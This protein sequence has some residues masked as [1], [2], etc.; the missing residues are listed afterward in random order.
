MTFKKHWLVGAALITAGTLA[1]TACTGGGAPAPA[2]AGTAKVDTAGELSGTI[3]FQ[4]W[5]LKNE[6]FTPYFTTLISDFT[7]E[8]PKVTI[9]W[10]DQPG[11]GY[12][13]KVL[14]QANSNSLPDVINL[15]NDIAYPLATTGKLLDLSAADPKLQAEYVA[16]AW[17]SYEYPGLKGSYGLPWYLGTDLSW[18]NGAELTKYGVDTAR[19]PTTNEELLALAKSVGEKSKGTMPLLSSMPSIDLFAASDIPILNDA[20]EFVFNTPQAAKI[21]DDY[22]A[23][24]DAGALPPEVLTGDYGGNADMFKQGKVAFTTAGSGFAGD[25]QKDAPSIAKTVIPTPRIGAAPLFTQGLSVSAGSQNKPAALAFATFATNTKNQVAFC[26][27]AAGFMPGTK[28]GSADYASLTASITDP[29]RKDAMKIVSESMKSAKILT[30]F[31][32]TSNMKTY[33]DQQ[34]ALALKGEI[35]SQAALDKIVKYANDNRVQ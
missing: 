1:L 30:P 25:L 32:W 4:T 7:K 19:L 28:A 6:K 8:H 16:G 29:L 20:G 26:T 3:K 9:E 5:S 14:S 27:L 31:Q 23:A 35:G 21:L 22:K 11:D 15:P 34:M 13:D 10:V 17:E 24:Y 12:Q 2:P 33:M 18:W